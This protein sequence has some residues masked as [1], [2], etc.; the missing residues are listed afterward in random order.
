MLGALQ[1]VRCPTTRCLADCSICNLIAKTQKNN[2]QNMTDLSSGQQPLL[3]V[4]ITA[5]HLYQC[6]AKVSKR[7]PSH[8]LQGR[9]SPRTMPNWPIG[10]LAIGDLK[11]PDCTAKL[12]RILV[13]IHRPHRLPTILQGP[14]HAPI[15]CPAGQSPK[16]SAKAPDLSA[17]KQCLQA[18]K[19]A[20]THL[21]YV[22]RKCLGAA[23]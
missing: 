9:S 11:S 3:V 21:Y 18:T 14:R 15:P 16:S 17:G 13:Q 20:P 23:W 8:P 1:S 19:S 5:S 22:Q 7:S 4:K 10:Q 2:A 6:V 12:Q